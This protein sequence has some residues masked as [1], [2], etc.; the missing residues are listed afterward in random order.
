[1]LKVAIVGTCRIHHPLL[2]LNIN[3]ISIVNEKNQSFV[4]N[5]GEIIQRLKYFKKL[6]KYEEKLNLYQIKDNSPNLKNSFKFDDIDIFIIEISSRKLIFYENHYL[7]WNNTINRLKKLNPDFAMEWIK[8]LHLSLKNNK[9]NTTLIMD[10]IL[11][12]MI[13]EDRDIIPYLG[14]QTQTFDDLYSDMME[15]NNLTNGKCI[16]ITHVDAQNSEGSNIPSRAVLIEKITS[17]CYDNDIFFINPTDMLYSIGQENM[18]D[19]NGLSV[20]H[21][22]PGKLNDIG[23]FFMNQ[24]YDIVNRW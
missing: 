24:I 4:H 16:F 21:Y 6:Y 19:S 11:D 3:E 7:Q 5:T 9:E 17:F 20:N 10:N 13:N 2:S 18:M 12:D 15:I 1:M 14:A 8:K 22:N 23:L